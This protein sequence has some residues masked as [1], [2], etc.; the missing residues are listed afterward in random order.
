MDIYLHTYLHTTQTATARGDSIATNSRVSCPMQRANTI[1]VTKPP[2]T[3]GTQWRQPRRQLLQHFR[4][5]HHF[6]LQHLPL[7][8][9]RPLHHQFCRR[10]SSPGSPP[11]FPRSLI[12]ARSPRTPALARPG[13]ARTKPT[14]A[15][16]C[17][18][19]AHALAE[20][21]VRPGG[22]LHS[23]SR[24]GAAGWGERGVG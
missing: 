3:L 12:V 23:L 13:R 20:S 4:R 16:G 19:K 6:L 7:H 17:S 21:T 14:C 10:R 24:L 9:L 22:G 8:R 18:F 15:I 2:T 5:L 11:S 1:T